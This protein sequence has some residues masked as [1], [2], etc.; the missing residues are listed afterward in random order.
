MRSSMSSG[1]T[2]GKTRQFHSERFVL[3][4]NFLI[5]INF[6]YCL[7][8]L[9]YF[10]LADRGKAVF[11][12]F[13]YLGVT[14]IFL[15]L[16]LI[17]RKFRR[18]WQI[19]L[20]DIL[21]IGAS[22]MWYPLS[23]SRI[24]LGVVLLVFSAVELFVKGDSNDRARSIVWFTNNSG[25]WGVGIWLL[26]FLSV[27]MADDRSYAAASL[28]TRL[29]LIVFCVF[30][31]EY[32]IQS[33]FYLIYDYFHRKKMIDSLDKK[34]VMRIVSLGTLCGVGISCI[35]YFLSGIV[36]RLLDLV[37]E[38]VVRLWRMIWANYTGYTDLLNPAQTAA[39]AGGE[40]PKGNA[41]EIIQYMNKNPLAGK[42]AV[43]FAMAILL[44]VI[45]IVILYIYKMLR[46]T[47]YMSADEEDTVT[48]IRRQ[49]NEQSG[50]VVVRKR[51]R[52]GN[53]ASEQIRRYYQ[54]LVYQKN[55]ERKIENL[56]NCTSGE[57][58][59]QIPKTPQEKED[60]K[61]MTALYDCAR[62][63]KELMPRSSAFRAKELY[64][65]ITGRSL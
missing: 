13:L 48:V 43:I 63:R 17:P 3:V 1:N 20:L 12:P 39:P 41:R 49:E 24:W 47:N 29:M 53:S 44:I 5:Q 7:L 9:G 8:L 30:F 34:H 54:K 32:L 2:S 59:Q 61:E 52:Y 51:F 57:L 36:A 10:L 37:L 6:Y 26:I 38:A 28:C 55:K 45:M 56:K 60:M 50:Q 14:G 23:Y 25:Y 58:A 21:V 42:I 40:T 31:A 27:M 46:T 22:V 4:I 33:Y 62:Y 65:K 19:I 18:L 35:V 11:Q 15:I 64:K 16:Y